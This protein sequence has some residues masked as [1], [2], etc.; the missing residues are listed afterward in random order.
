VRIEFDS[1]VWRWAARTDSSWFFA[2]VPEEL[3]TELHELPAPPRGF[4]SLRVQ[5]RIGT[6]RW[7]TSIFYNGSVYV[8][9]LKR[10]VREAEGVGEGDT[11]DVELDVLDL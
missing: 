10:A 6:T 7:R 5:A 1:D 4:S 2:S 8:L 3:S 9:P 11:I